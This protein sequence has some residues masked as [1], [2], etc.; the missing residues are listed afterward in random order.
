ME[1]AEPDE[2][3]DNLW[4][5]TARA[6]DRGDFSHLESL[7]TKASV[8]IVDLLDA[9]DAS[10]SHV[11]EALTWASFVGRTEV[12]RIL[13]D[14]GVDP[15]D[16]TSTGMSALHWAANRGNL[17]TVKL[18]IDH[19]A[20]L[21]Q[22]NMYDGT[23]LGFTLWSAIHEPRPAH[24]DIV[25]ALVAAGAEFDDDW[26]AWWIAQEAPSSDM[27]ERIAKALRRLQ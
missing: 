15:A 22:K 10:S 20:P 3:L 23:V 11:N 27:K 24:P 2:R 18:L 19:G 12:A 4:E 8:S 7:L 9:N 25:E 5:K 16:G 6:L 13:L 21:E 17:E 14:R 26:L 1:N